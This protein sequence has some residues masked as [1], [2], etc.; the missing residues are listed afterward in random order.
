MK[1]LIFYS[2]II[3]I[4]T[5]YWAIFSSLKY[6][7]W[8]ERQEK[9]TKRI[10]VYVSDVLERKT[11]RGSM[12]Y[13]PIFKWEEDGREYTIDSAYYSNVIRFEKNEEVV[14]LVNPEEY[15]QYMYGDPF[16]TNKLKIMDGI[17]C[18]FPLVF[19]LFIVLSCFIK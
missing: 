5:V 11:R 18:A 8:K 19:L 9:C 17:A 4:V 2:P 7:K 14:L 16:Y 3:V 15:R 6:K 13:K 1:E 10:T 12:V